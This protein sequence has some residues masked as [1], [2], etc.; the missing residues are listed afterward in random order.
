DPE[1]GHALMRLGIGPAEPTIHCVTGAE[2]RGCLLVGNL[3]GN[4]IGGVGIHQHILRVTALYIETRALQKGTE[5]PAIA[6]APFAASTRGLNPCGAHAVTYLP[7]CNI[8]RHGH[9]LA[10]RL[11]TEDPG[12]LSWNVSE[13]FVHVGVA[14][15]ACVHL[16][17]HLTSSGLR[18]RN[19]FDLPWTAYCGYNCSFHKSSS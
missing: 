7:R 18:L 9:D 11:V 19:L 8:R 16:H 1:H 4:Q 12:K 6:L 10:D 14:D 13:C 15:T 17:Q 2:D 5:H 3:V